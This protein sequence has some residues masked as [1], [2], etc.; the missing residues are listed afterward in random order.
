MT[1]TMTLQNIDISSWDTLYIKPKFQLHKE[2]TP[3]LKTP[4]D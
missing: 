2:R 4:V 3:L 1:D